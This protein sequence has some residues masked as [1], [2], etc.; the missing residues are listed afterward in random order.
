LIRP[1]LARRRCILILA[2]K[3]SPV[4]R[5]TTDCFRPG[6]YTRKKRFFFQLGLCPRHALLPLI[7]SSLLE[8]GHRHHPLDL[9]PPEPLRSSGRSNGTVFAPDSSPYPLPN[10]GRSPVSNFSEIEVGRGKQGRFLNDADMMGFVGSV[11]D[12]D[13]GAELRRGQMRYM[14]HSYLVYC[15]PLPLLRCPL[16]ALGKIERRRLPSERAAPPASAASASN[17]AHLRHP[18][19]CRPSGLACP[20]L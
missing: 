7:S 9:R 20:C 14:F 2:T 1:E 6:L 16:R 10:R 15:L 11:A 18:C 12:V 5:A 4:G 17:V 19:H 3:A 13:D 8:V